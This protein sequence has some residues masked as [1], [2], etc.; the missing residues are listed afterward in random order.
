MDPTDMYPEQ[1]LGAILEIEST[2]AFLSEQFS[3]HHS[4]NFFG[5]S[6]V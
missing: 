2:I 4:F 1:W 3:L 6:K 5:S